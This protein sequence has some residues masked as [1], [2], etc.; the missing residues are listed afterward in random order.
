[1]RIAH[2][3][4]T[5]DP[6]AGGVP[7]LV[8]GLATA[9]ARQGHEVSVLTADPPG[10][11][12]DDS[13]P[14]VTFHPCGPARGPFRLAAALR[15][16][17]QPIVASADVVHCHGVWTYTV[18]TAA[19]LAR[20]SGV[21]YV[22][23]PA[24]MLQA[25]ALSQKSLRKRIFL[26]LH[27][28][29]DLD[30][31]AALHYSSALER[32]SSSSIGLHSPALLLP[33]GLDWSGFE[34]LPIRGRFRRELEIGERRLVVCLAR[35]HPQKGL[36]LLVSSLEHATVPADVDVAIIGP[37][38]LGFASHL[39]DLAASHGVADR[40]HVLPPRFGTAKI[41]ALCD[42]DLF[43][44][45]SQQESFGIAVAEALAAGTPV[46]VS[47]QVGLADTVEQQHIGRSTRLDVVSLASTLGEML[48]DYDQL[49]RMGRA[50][51]DWVR[52][53][54]DWTLLV[55]RYDE[56]YRS[57]IET[58]EEGDSLD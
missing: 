50:G 42:A 37:E 6:K 41:E 20:R 12:L 28:R 49:A 14:S 53:T 26:A 51:R 45:P 8:S 39:K 52:K 21:P 17:A 24:G 10:T 32:E 19:G 30:G 44:L 36:E 46:L 47:D 11:D 13:L 43:C 40:V 54:L 2:F 48:S 16:A 15:A 18:H 55:P 25:W 23:S 9:Q 7:A 56:M 27:A 34:S 31:A 29:H 38:Q 5:I 4:T 58:R 35:I 1:M 57:A 22:F 3:S 33:N